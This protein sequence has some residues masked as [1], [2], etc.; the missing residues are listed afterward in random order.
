MLKDTLLSLITCVPLIKLLHLSLLV[1]LTRSLKDQPLNPYS[2]TIHITYI[3]HIKLVT[4]LS[5]TKC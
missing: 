4:K 1:N 5:V 3:I 2:L